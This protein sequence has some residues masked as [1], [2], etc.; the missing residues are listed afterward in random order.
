MLRFTLKQRCEPTKLWIQLQ[1]IFFPSGRGCH[2]CT[3]MGPLLVYGSML[4]RPQ[5]RRIQSDFHRLRSRRNW[6]HCHWRRTYRN[7][8]SFSAYQCTY[9]CSRNFF[10][11]HYSRCYS[12]F[13]LH[14]QLW[15]LL[16]GDWYLLVGHVILSVEKS[17]FV[18]EVS[19][20]LLIFDYFLLCK[21]SNANQA[22]C[23][24]NCNGFFFPVDEAATC[25]ARWELCSSTSDCCDGL[26]C[27]RFNPSFIACGLPEDGPTIWRALKLTWGLRELIPTTSHAKKAN[28][29]GKKKRSI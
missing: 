11:H 15:G 2:M 16:R 24:R 3:T 17:A 12:R 1:C 19:D 13:L 9:P 27:V 7:Q 22:N 14:H 26:T 21:Q 29:F 28:E 8:F 20:L 23:E 10:P 25:S 18:K 4:W 5:L 6:R